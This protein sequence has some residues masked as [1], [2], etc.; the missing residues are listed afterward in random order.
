MNSEAVFSA[1]FFSSELAPLPGMK[2]E[3]KGVRLFYPAKK[4]SQVLFAKIEGPSLP[5]KLCQIANDNCS[6]SFVPVLMAEREQLPFCF[7]NYFL[8][9]S[10]WYLSKQRSFHLCHGPG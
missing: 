9:G 7:I 8:P 3:R 6:I 1:A 4:R 10:L 2:I 5:G